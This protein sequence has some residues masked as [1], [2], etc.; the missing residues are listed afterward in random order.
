[1]F[2]PL[3]DRN[4]LKH[5]RRQYVT[6]GLIPANVV[7][8]TLATLAP[9]AV[10]RDR[11]LWH[12]FHPGRRLRY[13]RARSAAGTR[14][15]KRDLHHLFLPA[16]QLAASGLQHALPLGLRRQCRGRDGALQVP[17]LL[18]RLR[19]SRR[20][21]AWAGDARERSA[22]DR[23]VGR[24][25]GRRR[26]LSDAASAGCGSGYWSSCAFPCRFRPSSRFSSGWASN[27]SCW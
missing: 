13:R 22:A 9:E 16:W 20:A 14:A 11:G 27:S 24:G 3:H 21:G 18:H 15:G 8:H 2:I 10:L 17:V 4:A 23:G 5:I 1:M 6:L 7:T 25:V 26:G 19:R 12:G